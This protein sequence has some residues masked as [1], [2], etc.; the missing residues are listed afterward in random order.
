MTTTYDPQHPAYVDEADVRSELAR[1]QDVCHGCR[2][3]VD[4]C[5]VFPT[6]FEMLDEMAEPSSEMMTP[7]Q[8][9]RVVDE[10][11][12]CTMCAADCPYVPAL[13]DAAVDVPRLMLRARAM[14]FDNGHLSG[15]D[16]AA[17]RVLSRPDRIG[18]VAAIAPDLAN[19][20]AGSAA[21]SW[22][23]RL[24][25]RLTGVS[26]ERD[27]G[28]F[29]AERFTSWFRRRPT[30]K[31]QRRQAAITLFPTCLVE[32]QVT[33]VGKDL[34]KIYERNGVECGVSAARCCGAPLL[35]AGDIAAF[36]KVAEKNMTLLAAEIRAGTDVVVPE[37]A[38][39]HVLTV[40]SAGHVVSDAAQADASLVAEHT[41]DAAEYLMTL[42][43]G[44]DF[45]LDM[46][47]NG[48]IPRSVDYRPTSHLRARRIG[49][50]SRDLM[51]LTGAR[52]KVILEPAIVG[53][54]W[55]MRSGADATVMS[56]HPI[57]A[58]PP[59]DVGL[60]VS[61]SVLAGRTFAETAGTASVQH[62]VQVIA[63]AYGIS[64]DR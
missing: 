53:G 29:A 45:V 7:A 26:S 49:L 32:H 42:H 13:H 25:T 56:R 17:A 39:A 33:S 11:V 5:A 1:V 40:D 8:Q 57:A 9:D 47:F 59:V 51:R 23:R 38:C 62:P 36:R 3:C 64:D 63:D 18:R 20:I 22:P 31:L 12:H 28:T 37:P 48:D 55:S 58:A 4:L 6:L 16:R 43:S 35:H 30:I 54:I 15:N 27:L 41:Y 2:R 60:V 44:N 24:L 19:R 61:D 46:D 34:V 10:C 50:P 52:I 14:Q 21:G